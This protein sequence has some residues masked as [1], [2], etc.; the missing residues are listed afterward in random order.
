[1]SKLRLA[2]VN[3]ERDRHL[4]PVLLFLSEYKPDVVCIQELMKRDIRFFER[5][6][7][8]TSIYV[9]N[10][11]HPAEGKPGVMGLGI[12]STLP[13]RS[14]AVEY[15]GGSVGKL[16][17]FDHTS[18]ETR[19]TTE[20]RTVLHCGIE[21]AGVSFRIATTHFAWTPDGLPSDFQREDLG[22]ILAILEQMDEFV[23][24]GDFNAPRKGEIF[25]RLAAR[26]KDNIP[27]KYNWSVDLD[28][29]RRGRAHLEQEAARVGLSGFMVDGLFT[30][31]RY[32]AKDVELHNGISDHCAITAT[33][34][35][36]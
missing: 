20:N 17:D 36:V 15:Y 31:P 1:M 12:F 33:I 29:H 2:S 24:C 35:V 14:H 25:G 27:A 3:I 19:R 11:R 6:L 34:E 4:D 8:A 32:S 16:V 22:G 30:T 21:K 5:K 23:L 13:I 10:T 28:L 18:L 9:G 7:G 26:Y